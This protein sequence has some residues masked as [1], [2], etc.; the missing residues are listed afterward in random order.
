[1]LHYEIFQFFSAVLGRLQAMRKERSTSV[2]SAQN[3]LD[4]GAKF[5]TSRHELSQSDTQYEA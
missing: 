5:A 4:N 3:L 2:V 1:M